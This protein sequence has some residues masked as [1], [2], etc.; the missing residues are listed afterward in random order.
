MTILDTNADLSRSDSIEKETS[1]VSK[2]KY[3]FV[4]T[5]STKPIKADWRV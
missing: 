4:H 2:K 1:P 5:P 3:Q